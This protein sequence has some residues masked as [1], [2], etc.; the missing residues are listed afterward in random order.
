[1]LRILTRDQRFEK[2]M[3]AN[4]FRILFNSFITKIYKYNQEDNQN[5]LQALEKDFLNVYENM[6]KYSKEY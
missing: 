5:D 6:D 3:E 2:A 4:Q 1:M